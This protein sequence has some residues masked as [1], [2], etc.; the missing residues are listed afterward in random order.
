VLLLDEVTAALDSVSEHALHDALTHVLQVRDT[1]TTII[2]I[3]SWECWLTQFCTVG[4]LAKCRI[5]QPSSSRI[6]GL[7]YR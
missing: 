5:V 3:S 1:I 2:M 4:A 7:L 6:V